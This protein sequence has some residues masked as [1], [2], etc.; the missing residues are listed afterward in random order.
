[1]KNNLKGFIGLLLLIAFF[2][3]GWQNLSNWS[4]G[5]FVGYNLVGLIELI[6]GGWLFYSGIK[7]S[8]PKG[9]IGKN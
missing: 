9:N 7:G 1:M 2:T 6:G 4:S 5:E 3:S 8:R